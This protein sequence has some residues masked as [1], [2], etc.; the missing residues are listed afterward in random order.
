M[1]V[2][3]RADLVARGK[4]G[5]HQRRIARN[6]RPDQKEGGRHVL[7]PE[8]GEYL[9]G[10]DWIRSVIEGQGHDFGRHPVGVRVPAGRIDDRSAVDQLVRAA[11]T[12]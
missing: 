6:V 10:P 3:M 1:G 11:G 12:E 4:L 8:D 9:R 7:A 5:A 2:C